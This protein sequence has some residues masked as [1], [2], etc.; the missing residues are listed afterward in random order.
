LLSRDFVGTLTSQGYNLIQDTNAVT[1]AGDPTGNVLGVDPLLGPLQDNGGPT[2]T[3]AL[4]HAS[5]AIDQGS[6]GGLATDQRGAGRPMDDPTIPD[7][8]DGSDIGAFELE[9]LSPTVPQVICAQAVTLDCAPLTGLA[10]IVHATVTDPDPGETLTVT[11]TEGATT[12]DTQTLSSPASDALVTFNP[13]TLLPGL[14]SLT[15]WVSDGSQSASCDTS[16]TVNHDTT[17]PSI[18]C[19]PNQVAVATSP[20][21]AVVNYPAPIVSDDCGT[22]SVACS[23]QS[24]TVFAIG[25]TIVRC[26]ATDVG[27]NKK[28]STNSERS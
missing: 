20:A 26:E 15:I 13:V 5:P 1:F 10:V 9:P 23:P 7:A 19:P 6:L 11:L 14:H 17:P 12:H 18:T 22:P 3:H 2:L 27:A 28:G 8:A 21:G 24:G 16:V 25:D 4:L